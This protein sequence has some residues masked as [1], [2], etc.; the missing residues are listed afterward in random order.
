LLLGHDVCAGIETLTKTSPPQKIKLC[1]L[2]VLEACVSFSLG[3]SISA[4]LPPPKKKT[5]HPDFLDV[6]YS[7][8]K[9]YIQK[10][11]SQAGITVRYMVELT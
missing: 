1:V 11:K 3:F 9:Q 5:Q 8:Y 2:L 6:C 4:L 10:N 7:I